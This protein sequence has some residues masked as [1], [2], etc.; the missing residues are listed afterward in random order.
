MSEC[1]NS[2][3]STTEIDWSECPA[4]WR[5]AERMSGVWCFAQTRLPISTLFDHL[6]LG[7]SIDEFI[8][9]Y[10]PMDVER[11]GDTLRFVASHSNQ[12]LSRRE[13]VAA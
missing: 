5:D 3:M 6:A 9:W 7:R 11:V 4:V 10:P 1:D 8:E 13:L 12:A 2:D